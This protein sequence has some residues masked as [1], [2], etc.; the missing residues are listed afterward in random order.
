MN[1]AA[2]AVLVRWQPPTLRIT[3][4]RF[5]KQEQ[6]CDPKRPR[7]TRA[8]ANASHEETPIPA[9]APRGLR[10]S[11]ASLLYAIGEPPPVEMAELEHTD[12]ALA[13]SIHAQA[14]RRDDRENE[15]LSALVGGH[16]WAPAPPSLAI[17]DPAQRRSA[18]LPEPGNPLCDFCLR[19]DRREPG[20]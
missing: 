6:T 4:R 17:T 15:R 2:P 20:D 12:P 10:R 19:K 16:Q 7:R 1:C 11:F 13:L 14:L 3:G 18:R 8:R 5:C 9:P